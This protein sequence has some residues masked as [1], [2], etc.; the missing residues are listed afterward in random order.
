MILITQEVRHTITINKEME[1]INVK[2]IRKKL[3]SNN[4]ASVIIAMGLFII[5]IMISSVVIAAAASGSSRNKDRVEQQ[6]KYLSISSAAQTVMD[7]IKKL[8]KYVGREIT[9]EFACN[10]FPVEKIEYL[11]RVFQTKK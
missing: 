7:E 8:E 1:E 9:S 4:G 11:Q 5:C 3:Q 6:R 2:C 10:Q